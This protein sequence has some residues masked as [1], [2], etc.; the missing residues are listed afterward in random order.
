[1]AG[2]RGINFPYAE[3]F[4]AIA[5]A[6]PGA[7]VPW[8]DRRRREAIERFRDLG[9]PSVRV[10]EWKYTSLRGLAKTAFAPAI[11]EPLAIEAERLTAHLPGRF[12][13]PGLV[14]VNGALR[15]DLSAP[16]GLP[17]GVRLAGLASQLKAAPETLEGEVGRLAPVN[18]E[19]LIALNTALMTD[20]YLL[21]IDDGITLDAPVHLVFFGGAGEARPAWHMRNI[22]RLG[23]KSRATVVESHVG[24]ASDDVYWSNPV[25]EVTLGRGAFLRHYK[26]Q[27]ESHGASHLAHAKVA[28]AAESRYE[29]FAFTVG[30]GLSRNEIDVRFEGEG[31]DCHLD[32]V[33][34]LSARQH[35]DTTTVIDHAVPHCTSREVYKGVLDG[36]AH[37]VFQGR[38][39]VHPQAQKSD[40]HQ[41][42][43]ALLLSDKAEIDIKPELEIYADDVKCGHGATVGEL[44]KEALFYLQSRGIDQQRAQN[45]LIEGFLNEVLERVTFAPV[46]DRMITTASAWL[47]E[48]I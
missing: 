45:L 28:L 35:A 25:S 41:F 9:L 36:R 14:F 1:M 26:L 12:A 31:A 18:G 20:G 46:L 19:A 16:G 2:E 17:P 47:N 34:L 44:D 40:G 27:E 5:P 6:L 32:G 48:R 8:L 42:C 29:N 7:G 15:S 13:A 3:K 4:G 24:I 37:G 30:G 22:I 38:I 43:R 23:A 11:A 33:F 39:T 21:E 10:E